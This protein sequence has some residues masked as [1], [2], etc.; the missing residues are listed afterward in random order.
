MNEQARVLEE[1]HS[2]VFIHELLSSGVC[3]V[4]M[5]IL[6]S[7]VEIEHGNVN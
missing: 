6:T 5:H 3:R 2:T 7:V 4:V 1:V